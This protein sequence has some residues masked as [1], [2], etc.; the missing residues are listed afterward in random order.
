MANGLSG[1]GLLSAADERWLRGANDRANAAH[2]NPTEAS[3]ECYDREANPGACSWFK[4][5]ARHLSE[6]AAPY[7]ELLDHYGI[8]WT[9]LVTASPGRIAHEDEVQVVA[10]PWTHHQDWPFSPEPALQA[11]PGLLQD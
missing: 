8:P 3:P 5:S 4:E 1:E 7:L 2:P 6:L 9:E 11:G 10:V